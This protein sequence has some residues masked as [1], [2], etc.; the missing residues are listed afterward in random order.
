MMQ[1]TALAQD[2]SRLAGSSRRFAPVAG[3]LA[4]VARCAHISIPLGF[5]PVPITLQQHGPHTR[6]RIERIQAA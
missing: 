5:T 4:F 3:A 1:K 6:L 2:R